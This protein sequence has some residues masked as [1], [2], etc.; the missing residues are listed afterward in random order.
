MHTIRNKCCKL[1]CAAHLGSVIQTSNVE[2]PQAVDMEVK[3]SLDDNL[4]S[5]FEGART[6]WLFSIISFLM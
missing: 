6:S 4:S 1:T 2:A 5:L 3:G